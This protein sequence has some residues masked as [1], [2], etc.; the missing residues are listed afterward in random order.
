MPVLG[1]GTWHMAEDPARR[2]DELAAL[3]LGLDLGMTLIDTAEMYAAGA[4]E[5]LV[6]EAIRGRRDDV[7]VVTKV[8]PT[9]A[10][11]QA[12]T[13]ACERSL[14]RL[15]T[16][17]LDLYLLHWRGTLALES[18]VE[19][20]R[21]LVD[22]GKIRHWG[23]CNFDVVDLGEVMTLAGGGAVE[24]D[25]VL[26]NLAHREAESELLPWCRDEGLVLMAYSPIDQGRLLDDVVVQAVAARHRVS[27]AQVCLA[28]VLGQEGVVT[29]AK[30][31]TPAHVEDNRAALDL[32]LGKEDLA[33]LERAFP[34]PKGPQPLEIY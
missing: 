21:E 23:V 12:M 25:Q 7:F 3:R 29:I 34:P 16:D 9:S 19:A 31:G 4:A 2:G 5:E 14:R 27:P 17:R 32:Q 26:Y 22:S 10:Y 1:L 11:R 8:V 18:S 15:G 6:G 30:A 20:F 24:T 13:Q 28:W 33:T